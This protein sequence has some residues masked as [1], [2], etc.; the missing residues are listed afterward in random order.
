MVV[1]DDCTNKVNSGDQYYLPFAWNDNVKMR[2]DIDKYWS[3]QGSSTNWFKFLYWRNDPSLF[4]FNYIYQVKK[5]L[6]L[7]SNFH[8]GKDAT[9][10][11]LIEQVA[12]PMDAIADMFLR[13]PWYVTYNGCVAQSPY[14]FRP[15]GISFSGENI[16]PASY[17]GGIFLDKGGDI[18]FPVSPYYTLRASK[19]LNGYWLLNHKWPATNF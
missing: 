7:K 14:T 3:V 9:L 6:T 16:G 17:G 12:N 2:P 19:Y 4:E 18:R 15:V 11:V 13:D 8:P 10:S 1:N 5:S